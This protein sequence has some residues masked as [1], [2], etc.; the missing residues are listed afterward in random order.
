MS[1]KKELAPLPVI[2]VAPLGEI[3]AWVVLESELDVLERGSPS[4]I[5]LT[6]AV[7][8]LPTAL[9]LFVAILSTTTSDRVFLTFLCVGVIFLIVGMLLLAL[10]WQSHV[11]SRKLIEQIRN[12]MPPPPAI[13]EPIL[14]S[15]STHD[16][17]A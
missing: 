4:S 8:L 3:K 5:Y 6:F 2:R 17:T 9:S 14:I 16:Q 1:K 13:Q 7:A 10:W 15:E 12:R 11:S